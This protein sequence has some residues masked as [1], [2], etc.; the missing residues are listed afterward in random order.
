MPD[1]IGG[2]AAV[3]STGTSTG[4]APVE[5]S[6]AGGSQSPAF[7]PGQAPNVDGTPA[8]A[9]VPGGAVVPPVYTPN[10]KFKVLDKEHEID[11]L[12]RDIIKDADTEK[13]IREMHE[14]ALGL[15]SV[16]V[17]RQMLKEKI[18]KHYAPLE[19]QHTQTLK[20]LQ[21]VDK[22]IENSD[23]DNFFATLQIPEQKIME[24]AVKKAQLMG[25]SPQEQQ[26]YN[27]QVQER[28]QLYTLQQQNADLSEQTFNF[29]VQARTTE[30]AQELSKPEVMSV[31][32]A[33][34]TRAG[35]QGA[36]Q[37]EVIKRGQLYALQGVD[38]PVAQ[39]VSEVLGLV[40]N[41]IPQAPAGG[42]LPG[43]V[44]ATPGQ[45]SQAAPVVKP[46]VIPNVGGQ[47]TS[48]TKKVVRSL[49][50]IRALAKQQ[51]N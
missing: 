27:Q 47:G 20:S 28:N 24:W 31:V 29:Q 34:D 7:T 21:V 48:P 9:V 8:P 22:M 6:G 35:K 42:Q 3:E 44:T 4:A 23:F 10:F 17:D 38:A 15:D 5:T 12:F 50:D 39:V 11:P 46:P 37:S 13:K 40:G 45:Q 26:A 1:E 19:Q 30:L 36:F 43:N 49:D 14:K 41:V 16:K 51:T 2:T 33:F 25:L 18:E 32:T